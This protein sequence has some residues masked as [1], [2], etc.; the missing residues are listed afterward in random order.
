M[1]LA[2]TSSS[3]PETTPTSDAPSPPPPPT[4][5]FSMIDRGSPASPTHI[6]S[7]QRFAAAL[8]KNLSESHRACRAIQVECRYLVKDLEV[9]LK[10]EIVDLIQEFDSKL[11]LAV[12]MNNSRAEYSTTPSSSPGSPKKSASK[13]SVDDQNED[14]KQLIAMFDGRVNALREDMK[15]DIKVIERKFDSAM[16]SQQEHLRQTRAMVEAM[17]SSL[18]NQI[19][20]IVEDTQNAF[21]S[22]FNKYT[23]LEGTVA[24]LT[25]KHNQM[26]AKVDTLSKISTT[27]D[28]KATASSG[29]KANSQVDSRHDD[30]ETKEEEKKKIKKIKESEQNQGT[31]GDE[32]SEYA[33]S[34]VHSEAPS[35]SP[36]IASLE[37]IFEKYE[38]QGAP[39]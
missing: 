32:V 19:E 11:K 27:A 15:S 34:E 5:P 8:K 6:A 35:D 9:E 28:S 14:T 7:N 37:P 2:S 26:E 39:L 29:L 25:S 22:A 13:R 24:Q 21:V 16:R 10:Q 12:S 17:E 23:T 1:S 36:S 4:S 3:P 30:E 33:P 31:S 20:S 38:D 18:S